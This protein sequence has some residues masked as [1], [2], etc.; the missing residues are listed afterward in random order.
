MFNK[1]TKGQITAIQFYIVIISIMIGTG[2]LNLATQVTK[3]SMQDA[4]ISVLIAG[5]L[6]CIFTYLSIF[7]A[8]HFDEMT[9]FQYFSY[10]L[11]KPVT[12]VISILYFIYSLVV[13]SA[14][15][16]SLADMI[17]TWFLPRTPLWVI[18]LIAILTAVNLT[19]DGITIVA[20]FS[21]ILFYTLF[22]MLPL[23]LVSINKLSLLNVMPVGGTGF[24]TIAE[25]ALPSVFTYAG[26]EIVLFIYPLIANK[27]KNIVK[28]SVLC[29]FMV[30]L[31]YTLTVFTQIALFGYQELQTILY[32]TINYLDVVDFLIIERIEVFFS[33]FWI[34][35]VIATIIIQ[36]FVGT[37]VLQKTFSTSSN[38]IFVYIFSP[39]VFFLSL[40]PKNAMML[41]S[42][43][44]YIGYANLF[45][46]IA[47]PLIL[48]L[49]FLVRGRKVKI[50]EKK[51]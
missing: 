19:K 1:Y 48:L 3:I 6:V 45:F 28:T 13:T 43:K 41:G 46:G 24:A 26:Y 9:F 22:P 7:I 51:K 17:S 23:I 34:Y 44:E 35:T 12:Y 2:I 5:I 37:Y 49:M 10:L 21:Q 8:S 50:D 30:T 25:G 29:V 33:I 15:L 31:I 20:R 18:I 47:L 32:P 27:N 14:V 42:I 16:R 40:Y 38:G 36:F 39:V 11:S 4:W